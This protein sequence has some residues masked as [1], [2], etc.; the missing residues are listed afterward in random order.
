M[1]FSKRFS[2]PTES[3]TTARVEGWASAA[4][5]SGSSGNDWPMSCGSSE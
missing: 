4:R 3:V 5:F 2:G 1:S